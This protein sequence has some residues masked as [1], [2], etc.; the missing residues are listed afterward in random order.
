MGMMGPQMRS[1]MAGGARGNAPERPGS[2]GNAA[3]TQED[4]QGVTPSVPPS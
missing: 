1:G 4:S 3:L 2:R